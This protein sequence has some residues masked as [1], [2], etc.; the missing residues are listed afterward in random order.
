MCHL[1]TLQTC[2]LT[3]LGDEELRILRDHISNGVVQ[4]ARLADENSR[5][6]F[7]LQ[8]HGVVLPS[9][10]LEQDTDEATIPAK[11]YKEVI[12]QLDHLNA[13]NQSTTRRIKYLERKN[14]AVMQK[15]KDMKDSVKAWQEYAERHLEKKKV[16]A[17]GKDEKVS[18]SDDMMETSV[19][20][21]NIPSSPTSAAMRTPRCVISE[22]RVSVDQTSELPEDMTRIQ[23]LGVRSVDHIDN[24]NAQTNARVHIPTE[25]LSSPRLALGNDLPK[26]TSSS[27]ASRPD[28]LEHALSDKITSSQRTVSE[29]EQDHEITPR[30]AVN[31]G[32]DDDPQ[33]VYERS[34]K[35][36]RNATAGYRVLYDGSSDGTPARPVRIKEEASRSSPSVNLT[37]DVLLRKDTMDL[38][39]L[40]PKPIVTPRRRRSS[41]VYSGHSNATGTLR[42]Q[43]SSS[44][45]FSDNLIKAE[46]IEE[47]D[48]VD[49]IAHPRLRMETEDGRAESELS[50]VIL[51][52]RKILQPLDT[53]VVAN[54]TMQDATSKRIKTE[55]IGDETESNTVGESSESREMPPPVEGR[56]KKLP[57]SLARAHFN[58]RIRAAKSGLTPTKTALKTPKSAPAKKSVTQGLTPSSGVSPHTPSEKPFQRSAPATVPRSAVVPDDRPIWRMSAFESSRKAPAPAPPSDQARG[59]LR[60]LPVAELRIQDFKANP[61]Y[62]GGYTHAFTDTVRRR[63][64]RLC[65]P[66]C[67]NPSCCGSTFRTL[68]LAA[69]R[70][71][72]SQEEALLQDY[73]GDAYDNFGLT[74]MEK[75]ERDEIVLQ[76][77]TRQLATEHGKHRRAYEG[78]KTPPGFWRMDFP[79][80]QE[81]A[82]DRE[83][84]AQMEQ[85]EIR[86]RWLEA[87]RRGGK[88]TFA[89]E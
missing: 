43:R 80:T 42:E 20:V 84:A 70:L 54:R 85:S 7:L 32:E 3:A 29:A 61:A 14:I 47:G 81:Q 83:K 60:D 50:S 8:K 13:C 56:K 5:L 77:R 48:R 17:E 46:P 31:V 88:Y 52:H 35:R 68:A 11:A 82:E 36:K 64:D 45:P 62:N 41:R 19:P 18:R 75:T 69:P 58:E 72:S 53:N 40:G 25:K 79:N 63:E 65:L 33:F 15:N 6:K 86:N 28:F 74:Q 22:E 49:C 26:N 38:D 34:L 51:G 2:T 10:G 30:A 76:A 55:H 9:E 73:L 23:T 78:R 27:S 4:R 24:M 89:D 39:E 66:G 1:E 67:T 59:R 16:K 71:S 44:A 87:M 57:P 21:P 37:V 12:E